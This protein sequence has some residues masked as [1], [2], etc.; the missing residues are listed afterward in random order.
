MIARVAGI[1]CLLLTIRTGAQSQTIERLLAS[2]NQKVPQEKIHIHF[3]NSLYT[4]GQTIWCKAYLLKNNEPSDLSKNLYIDWFDEQGKFVDRLIAPII[5]AGA[6]GSFTIPKNFA[7]NHLQVLAY[8]KWMLNFDSA[9]LFHKTIPIAQ[10]LITPNTQTDIITN[11]ILR[12]FPEGGDMVENILSSLA[13]KAQNRGGLPADVKGIITDKAG[14]QVAA[15]SSV[16]DGMGKL[17][18]TP[19]PGEIYTAE[20]QDALG[21]KRYTSLPTAKTEGI[22]LA[23]NPES[24]NPEF[25]IER[26]QNSSERFTKGMIVA[27]MNQHIV[28][29]V[30]FDFG[31]KMKI[32][33][34]IPIE[35]LPSGILQ[36]TVFDAMQQPLAERIL[37]V[38][39]ENY[40]L[41]INVY[42]D[43]INLNARGKN[44]FEI[45]VPDTIATSL[46]LAVTDGGIQPD[47]ANNIISQFLLSGE[48]KGYVNDPAYYFSPYLDSTEEHLDLV[49]LTNGWRRFRWEDIWNSKTPSLPYQPDTSYLSIS[50]KIDNLKDR[51][52]KKAEMMNLI[53][54]SKDSSSRYIFSPLHEDG[55]FEENGLIFFDSTKVF[56]QLNKVGL[57]GHSTIKIRNSF[58]TVDS[59]GKI[60]ALQLFMTDTIS[61]A[62]MKLLAD[63]QRRLDSLKNKTT[64]KEVVVKAKFKTRLQQIDEKY[65]SGKYTGHSKTIYELNLLDDKLG[66][67]STNMIEYLRDS[68][69][70]FRVDVAKPRST[71][72]FGFMLDE[73]TGLSYDEVSRIPVGQVAY[74]KVWL[75]PGGDPGRVIVIYTKKGKDVYI[76]NDFTGLS[77]MNMA[78]YSPVKEVYSPDYSEQ[79]I[80]NTKSDL[81]STLYWKPNIE[82]GSNRQK[83]KLVFYNNDIS[84]SLRVVLEG[85]AADGRLIHFSK[86]LQ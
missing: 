73:E 26:L 55:S 61:A 10:T 37:F 38:N 52:I 21:N 79:A 8:T 58:L 84:H 64:L 39:N 43:T 30:G 44:V 31:E 11:T 18:F 4:P 15:F 70:W 56:Y 62:R 29:R 32:S 17:L 40:R 76:N 3:D 9:F 33:S 82:T 1:I 74:V 23:I 68:L 20:W 36:V 51:L 13:F 41:K 7:G 86:L 50:G 2:Y 54:L 72:N 14:K 60:R 69:P 80:N 83:V 49:M 19:M 35:G 63:E 12:F 16:H 5:Q 24:V 53:L 34:L 22:V 42:I 65:T 81:R 71:A 27:Q 75:T 48:I 46:S 85:I 28:F 66:N 77:Y 47:S 67:T 45:D 78:G 25:S 6:S 57:Q 59:T